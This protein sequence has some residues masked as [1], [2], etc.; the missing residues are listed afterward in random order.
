MDE[1]KYR[2]KGVSERVKT[3]KERFATMNN[4]CRSRHAWI[5]S[6]PGDPEIRLET[7]P[8]STLPA[9]LKRLGYELADDGEGE[10]IIP[11][12]I[13]ERFIR[14]PGGELVPL[15]AGS[16]APVAETRTHAGIV[17]TERFSFTMP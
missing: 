1:T 17:K 8:N 14:G 10:R 11:G 7:L 13:I 15:V 9:E 12:R 16:T 2:P 6:V 5:I 3:L 4:F